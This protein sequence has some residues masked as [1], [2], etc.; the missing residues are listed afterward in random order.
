MKINNRLER[1]VRATR[2]WREL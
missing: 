2:L 1:L